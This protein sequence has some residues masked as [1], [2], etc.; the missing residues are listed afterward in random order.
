[1][2]WSVNE[3]IRQFCYRLSLFFINIDIMGA[4]PPFTG[5]GAHFIIHAVDMS[6]SKAI[7]LFTLHGCT[8][9][10]IGYLLVCEKQ[11]AV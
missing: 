7:E 1:M 2:V 8:M 5:I 4:P 6:L 3:G 11:N 9:L 10:N